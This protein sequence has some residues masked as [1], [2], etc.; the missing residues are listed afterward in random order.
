MEIE[1]DGRKRAPERP[2]VSVLGDAC[3]VRERVDT[4]APA[5]PEAVTA[6]PKG[7]C[8]KN[9]IED[10]DDRVHVVDV[11]AG[12]TND[13]FVPVGNFDDVAAIRRALLEREER[14]E[15]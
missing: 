3:V 7:L 14:T 9:G 11:G 5:L 13:I 6:E 12:P 1:T 15:P 10:R 8:T 2:V 4:A